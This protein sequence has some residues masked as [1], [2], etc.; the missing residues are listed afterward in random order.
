MLPMNTRQKY[1]Q[2][3]LLESDTMTRAHRFIARHSKNRTSVI[4]TVALT[5][6]VLYLL[7][8]SSM[9]SSFDFLAPISNKRPNYAKYPKEARAEAVKEAFLHAYG[10]Y[11]R[12][13]APADELRPLR[14]SSQQKCVMS[15]MKIECM[16]TSGFSKLQWLGCINVRCSRHHVAHESQAGV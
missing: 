4:T 2:R 7:W 1:Y 11:E 13:A 12:Y 14:N 5:L 9:R 16:L 8:P 6:F 3:T 10:S 15:S